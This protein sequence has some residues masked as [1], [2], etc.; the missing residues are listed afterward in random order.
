MRRA[1]RRYIHYRCFS[2]TSPQKMPTQ[3]TSQHAFASTRSIP[4]TKHEP[5]TP[6]DLQWLFVRLFQHYGPR[7]WW[8]TVHGGDFELIIG[9]I[10]VQNVSWKSTTIAIRNM[11][12][13]GV[14]SFQAILS[15]D[16]ETLHRLVRPT[17]YWRMKTRKLK[18]F[19]KFLEQRHGGDL[20]SLFALD[21]QEMRQQLIAVWGI[22][23]ETA[24]DIVLYG[25]NKPS[26][27]IDAYT[28]RLLRR[29]GFSIVPDSYDTYQSL[30]HDALPPDPYLFNEYHALID[31]HSA[32]ICK[33]RPDCTSCVLEDECPTGLGLS[34]P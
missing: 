6:Q 19:A 30:F 31:Y 25:A 21:I 7:N 20:N 5:P 33:S 23:P 12:E 28:K 17:V 32:R 14:W 15:T 27:V 24:D 26:F 34:Q 3:P 4:S 1:C 29:L 9:A 18:E 13:A 2:S 10:L 16:D 11:R 22:G 8:P